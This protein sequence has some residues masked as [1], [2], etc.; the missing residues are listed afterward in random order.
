MLAP[1]WTS[2]RPCL[3]RDAA[4]GT[5]ASLALWVLRTSIAPCPTRD[6]HRG[7]GVTHPIIIFIVQQKLQ[8]LDL[9]FFHHWGGGVKGGTPH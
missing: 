6:P 3:S 2:S 8:D 4:M 1:D 7:L 5:K 9:Q